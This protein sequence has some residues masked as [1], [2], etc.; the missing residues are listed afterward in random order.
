VAPQVR[1]VNQLIEVKEGQPAKLEC[2]VVAG[3][4]PIHIFWAKQVR[5]YPYFSNSTLLTSAGMFYQSM[6]ARNRVG[7]GLSYPSPPELDFFKHSMRAR[8][9]VRIGLSY[10]LA[11]L[12]RLAELMP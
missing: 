12:H 10:R 5:A 8:N 2:E 3:S 6:G 11:R 1:A 7:I 4:L 9:Q